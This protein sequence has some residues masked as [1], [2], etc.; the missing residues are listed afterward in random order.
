MSYPAHRLTD[1]LQTNHNDH[2][3]LYW[4]SNYTTLLTRSWVILLTDWHCLQTN[5]NDHTT[6]HWRSNYTT[7]LTRSWVILLTDWQTVYRQTT[8]ITQLH[9]DRVTTQLC[10]QAAADSIPIRG[11]ACTAHRPRPPSG[12]IGHPQKDSYY[13]WT[14]VLW[15]SMWF[16]DKS[17]KIL[18]W[19]SFRRV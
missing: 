2:T 19:V 1:C 11:R 12:S 17:H 14:R 7:L 13:L 10:I 6:P 8:T 9:I 5:H 4:R 18:Y 16:L 3:T 15:E